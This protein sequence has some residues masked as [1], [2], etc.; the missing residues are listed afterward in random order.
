MYVVTDG[1][2]GEANTRENFI[3]NNCWGGRV[4]RDRAKSIT[5]LKG[6]RDATCASTIELVNRLTFNVN[7][8]PEPEKIACRDAVGCIQG[9]TEDVMT[10]LKNS[11]LISQDALNEALAGE[12]TSTI[13]GDTGDV[14]Y[15]ICFNKTLAEIQEKRD[16]C[17]SQLSSSACAVKTYEPDDVLPQC[18]ADPKKANLPQCPSDISEQFLDYGPAYPTREGGYEAATASIR[19]LFIPC[20]NDRTNADAVGAILFLRPI[21]DGIRIA[22]EQLRDMFPEDWPYVGFVIA[23][24]VPR[25][26]VL[27]L[28]I[29]LD[30]VVYHNGQ[31]Q[32]A[33]IQAIYQNTC[34]LLNS[35]AAIYDKVACHCVTDFDTLP[36]HKL[37]YCFVSSP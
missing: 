7:N 22:L 34:Q 37:P 14:T 12:D 8:L 36:H 24:A 6:Q 17:K 32:G 4:K 21:F 15:E 20:P 26:I 19:E 27:S 29:V 35:T 33:K 9:K 28:D 2:R 10:K 30:Q 25:V 13:Y 5:Q 11:Q 1:D 23:A 31:I 16:E 3:V 18:S